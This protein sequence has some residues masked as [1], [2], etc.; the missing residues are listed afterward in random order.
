[1]PNWVVNIHVT[2]DKNKAFY[3]IISIAV[4]FSVF[5]QQYIYSS[6]YGVVSDCL[7][8]VNTNAVIK[9]RCYVWKVYNNGDR[10]HGCFRG[11]IIEHN[12]YLLKPSHFVEVD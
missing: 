10:T 3:L 9:Q 6:F 4:F 5:I 7:D 1:M 8:N 2:L 11:H 12:I